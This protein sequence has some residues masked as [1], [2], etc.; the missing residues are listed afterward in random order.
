MTFTCRPGLTALIARTKRLVGALGQQPAGLIDLAAEE[1]CAGVAMYTADVG[2]DVDLDDVAVLQGASIGD[3]VADD[4]IDRRAARLGKP[5]IA[6]RRGIC[7]V[8]DQE[9]VDHVIKII[10][11]HPGLMT[12]AAACIAWA[13]SRPAIRIFSMVS[14]RL[15]VIA[16]VGI[17]RGVGRHS[18]AGE[19]WLAPRVAAI[20]SP[21][22]WSPGDLTGVSTVMRAAVL[23]RSE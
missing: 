10:G 1:G 14:A 19:C 20:R 17:G 9:L 8:V 5:A 12:A 13:A 11:G 7:S 21:A 23:R 15:D 2:G 6:K 3:A 18:A 22:G 4:L 16:G